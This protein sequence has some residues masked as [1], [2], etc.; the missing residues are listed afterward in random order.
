MGACP[1]KIA[2]C[3]APSNSYRTAGLADAILS[4]GG[5]EP[6]LGGGEASWNFAWFWGVVS[7]RSHVM[8]EEVLEKSRRRIM[9]RMK[10]PQEHQSLLQLNEELSAIDAELDR[11]RQTAPV[12]T[13]DEKRLP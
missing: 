1:L 13:V 6:R 3:T 8:R 11:L 9:E 12:S 10:Q 5:A 4:F 2:Y 7:E